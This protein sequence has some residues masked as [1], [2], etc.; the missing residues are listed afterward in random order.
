[1]NLF[2]FNVEIIET[3]EGYIVKANNG[4]GFMNFE[5]G[6]IE[7]GAV[8]YFIEFAD[9]DAVAPVLVGVLQNF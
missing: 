9:V 7:C 4:A 1:M 8:G 5:T 2:G 3:A 6:D